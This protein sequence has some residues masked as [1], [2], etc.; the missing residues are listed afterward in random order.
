MKRKIIGYRLKDDCEKYIPVLDKISGGFAILGRRD[1]EIG[2]SF[3]RDFKQAEVL[4]LWFEPVYEKAEEDILRQG[5][6]DF[7]EFHNIWDTYFD[8]EISFG[9]VIHRPIDVLIDKWLNSKK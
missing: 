1:F 6:I 4:D 5:I 8:I 3:Y 2:Y 9:R 7:M